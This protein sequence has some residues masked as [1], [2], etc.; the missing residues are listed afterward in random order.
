MLGPWKQRVGA[1][2]FLGGHHPVFQHTFAECLAL[3]LVAGGWV[4]KVHASSRV[5]RV[6]V[7]HLCD[8]WMDDHPSFL[9]LDG[10]G[11]LPFFGLRHL[12]AR[13]IS[14]PQLVTSVI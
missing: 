10:G 7:C 14:F 5:V 9:V 4:R 13:S 3:Q 1:A 12:P 6:D 8:S 2:S 11:K